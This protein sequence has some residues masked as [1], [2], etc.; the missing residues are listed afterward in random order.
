MAQERSR[1]AD[2]LVY[3]LVRL[4]VCI[5]QMLSYRGGR[6]LARGLAWLIHR[7]DRRHRQVADE[8]LRHAFGD[9]LDQAARDRMVRQV[10]VHFCTMLIEIIQLPRLLHVVNWKN[11]AELHGGDRMV[12]GLLS[13]RPM[14]IV[15]GHLGNWEVAGYALGLFGFS[16]HAIARTLDNPY[17]DDF[18]RNFRERTGQK[19]LAKKGDFDQIQELLS[20]NG[21][22]ATLADQDAGQRGQFVDFFNRPAST[23]KAVALLALEYNTPMLVVGVP[24]LG[25]G[26][27]GA[28]CID[29]PPRYQILLADYIDPQEYQ[30]RPDAV[31][32][33]TQRYT[34]ALE[35]VIRLAPEQYFW[36][37]RRW[38]HQ[39]KAR[40]SKKAA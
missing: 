11:F 12:G 16:T 4:L 6:Q 17:L 15:T 34:T 24:R 35:K 31:A 38:K 8:N 9:Q 1:I 36:L 26:Q 39:P 5:V 22:I 21:V 13:G 14:M 30:G 3:L 32:A 10:Y 19:I 25:K 27:H 28:V 37:H 20:G 23:H 7:I 40:K 29:G 18:L 33:I 2:Y